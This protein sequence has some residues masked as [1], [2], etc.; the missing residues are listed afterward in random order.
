MDRTPLLEKMESHQS[1]LNEAIMKSG[2]YFEN[3]SIEDGMK[4]KGVSEKLWLCFHCKN[5]DGR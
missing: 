3:S 5:T 4:E 2:T 1:I